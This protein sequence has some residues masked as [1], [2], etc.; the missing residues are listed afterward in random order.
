M[1]TYMR[2]YLHLPRNWPNIYR[3]A[4]FFEQWVRE[5]ET[6]FVSTVFFPFQSYGFEIIKRIKEE[7]KQSH[8]RP[9]Y[10]LRVPRV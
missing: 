10:A 4:I 5:N 2:F 9:G 7:V 1:K 8:Y 3:S 6:H